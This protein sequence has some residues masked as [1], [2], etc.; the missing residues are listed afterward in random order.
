MR[1]PDACWVVKE[2]LDR[3]P[4]S[5]LQSFAHMCPDFIIEIPS[6]TDRL[7]DLQLKMEEYMD[8][9]CRLG[10][11]IDPYD[12]KAWIYRPS[13]PPELIADFTT[14]LPGEEVLPGFSLGLALFK[15]D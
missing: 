10:F 11:L 8:N 2:R 15:V 1:A 14:S 5:D 3:L 4:K 7:K 12:K 6:K 9:G 13:Q